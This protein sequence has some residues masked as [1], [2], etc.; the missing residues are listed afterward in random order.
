MKLN[1]KWML[2][3][4]LVL[5][6]AMATTGTLAYLTDEDADVNTMT[7]GNVEIDLTE[8]FDQRR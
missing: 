2:L 3:A 7:L 1:R 5:S 6:V 8:D 4:A